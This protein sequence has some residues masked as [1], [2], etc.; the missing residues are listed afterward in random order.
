[1]GNRIRT[2]NS[3][4]ML[5]GMIL[6]LEFLSKIPCD[7]RLSCV[8]NLPPRIISC[9]SS[10]QDPKEQPELAPELGHL[11]EFA[12]HQN[13]Q[14]EGNMNGW[15][16][17]DDEEEKE[18]EDPEMEEEM[19]V[20][21]D[22]VVPSV[23]VSYFVAPFSGTVYVGSGPSRQVFAPGPTGRDV[24]T[25]HRQFLCSEVYVDHVTLM[26]LLHPTRVLDM[27]DPYVMVLD[28]YR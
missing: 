4:D 1:M 23:W 17:E 11:N 8:A 7:L 14:P 6:Q 12:L 13:P 3:P 22:T 25:L 18:E 9:G 5:L 19:T 10:Q 26:I 20:E 2:K 27:I 24:N 15:I 16:L 28:C 21:A